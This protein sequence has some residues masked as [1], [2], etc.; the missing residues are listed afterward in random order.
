[1]Q[2]G[3]NDYFMAEN[4]CVVAGDVNPQLVKTAKRKTAH[5]RQ[6]VDVVVFDANN[7]PF[8]DKSFDTAL[9]IDVLEHL[10]N[11]IG[12]PREAERV[13]R[14]KMLVNVPNYDFATTLSKHASRTL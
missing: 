8:R 14:K 13:G 4:H 1:M 6:N 3:K 12:A 10:R 2:L 7:F 5:Y 9:M 11:P